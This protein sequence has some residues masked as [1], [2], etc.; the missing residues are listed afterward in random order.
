MPL[1]KK[2]VRFEET[3][4]PSDTLP[5]DLDL[6]AMLPNGEAIANVTI[7]PASESAALGFRVLNDADYAPSQPTLT[8]IRFYPGIEEGSRSASIWSND[9]QDCAVE[10]SIE[11][12]ATPP[13]KVQ[14]SAI[15]RVEQL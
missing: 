11:T 9:G 13:N 4:D 5:F 7:G 10:V 15:V 8:S 2:A 6:A 1:P 12:D 3:I 14:R